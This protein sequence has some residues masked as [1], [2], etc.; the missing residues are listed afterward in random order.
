[1]Y[2]KDKI[3][4]GAVFVFVTAISWTLNLPFEKVVSDAITVVSIAIAVYLTAATF[5]MGSKTATNMKKQDKQISTK[6]QL[7]VL[8]SYL[9]HA[10]FVGILSILVGFVVLLQKDVAIV[11]NVIA[12]TISSLGCSLFIITILFMWKI[13]R[14]IAG[15][16]LKEEK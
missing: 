13:F 12:K 4:F 5:L 6:T 7:G 10:V 2:I 8:V 14:F 15:A 11:N 16:L 1:M 3:C 9:S